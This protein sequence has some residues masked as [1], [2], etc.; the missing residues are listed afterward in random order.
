MDMQ[1]LEVRIRLHGICFFTKEKK[2]E[3]KVDNEYKIYR[4][5]LIYVS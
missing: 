5:A 1:A 3:N 2:F 4:N